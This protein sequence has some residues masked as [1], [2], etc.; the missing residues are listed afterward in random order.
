MLYPAAMPTPSPALSVPDLIRHKR[1]GGAHSRA[2]LDG[3]IGGY[4]RGEV[5]DYQVA[6]WLMAVCFQG[7]TPQETADLTLAMAASGE[8][9]DLGSLP[10]TVDKHSTGGV[11][12]KTSL[13][14]TPMLAALGL[15]V[16]K[17]SGRGLAHT[18][19]TIDKLESIPGWSPDLP[20]AAFLRQAREIGLALVGQSRDLAPADGLL[21][22]LRDVTAT[23]DC[24]PLI[25]SS[26]MSKKLASGAQ[27]LVLDVKVG[28]GAFMR[29]LEDGL[30]LA[31]VMVDIG[32][33]AGR[34]VR[35]VLTDMNAPL[36]HMA[37][38]SLEVQEAVATLRGGGPD[39]LRELC[40]ALA[41]EAL[42]AAGQPEDAEERARASLEDGSALNK[43]WAFVAAQGGD[44]AFVDHPER[45]DVAPDQL[46]LM[47]ARDGF[48]TAVD[49]LGVGRAVLALG[50][51]R[52]RKGERIDHGVGVELLCK[53]GER[54]T[55]G[56]PVTRLYSR[57]GRGL[58]RARGLLEAG[59]EIGAE[60]PEARP[61]ILG[62]VG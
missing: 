38:N 26:I 35:S 40:V 42:A 49:S 7:M 3:L 2:D 25:A 57:D 45:L 56:Q 4:T 16:A 43:L 20:E 54:V 23:V 50:G 59:L 41:V 46:E 21:Y 55:K 22:A 62:R 30:G 33:H 44:P 10:L 53:P 8:M 5:P 24:L 12:D 15:T 48:V 13:V 61:L 17:M 18:G 37:G 36:G 31:R 28:A 60:P 6:A 9:L 32:R 58:E 1:G 19:G 51:G 34:E 27:C 52:E 11:G 14:L 39:D 47:A 29:T